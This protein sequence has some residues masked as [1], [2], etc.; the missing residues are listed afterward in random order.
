MITVVSILFCIENFA[1]ASSLVRVRASSLVRVRA[2]SLVR[3][4]A[5]SFAF[6]KR[7]DQLFLDQ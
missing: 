6:N 1:G 2:S 3:V 7:Q 5:S 4:R